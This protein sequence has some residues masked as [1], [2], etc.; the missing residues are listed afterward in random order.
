MNQ[1]KETTAQNFIKNLC[2]GSRSPSR[3]RSLLN[4]MAVDAKE[5]GDGCYWQMKDG[6]VV[7]ENGDGAFHAA[8]AAR[9]PN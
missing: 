4:S 1:A 6:S 2:D 9:F 7:I 3:I 8:P 5:K